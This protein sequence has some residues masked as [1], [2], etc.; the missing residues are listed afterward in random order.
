ML[1]DIE[2]IGQHFIGNPD[3]YKGKQD[4]NALGFGW[5]PGQEKK[6]ILIKNCKIDAAGV[7]E[8]LKLSYC[9]DVTVQ[10]CEII[11]G[12]ED[13]VD[14]VRGGNILFENCR[15]IAN[16]TKHHFTIKC[17]VSNVI[18]KNCTFINNFRHIY[19]GAFVDMG[20]W[21]IYNKENI[22]KT[23]NIKIINCNFENVSWYKRILS[24]AIY[25]EPAIAENTKGFNL[26]IPTLFV[27][28]F[29]AFKRCQAKKKK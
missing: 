19:D 22:P 13:C 6:T 27:N 17:M 5:R 18:I 29:W 2:V 14:I 28:I 25:A 21:G 10:D 24:R 12:Y 11:G 8:G 20:N 26:K 15:F 7:A 9:H 23:N 3:R 4:D 16:N 1:R